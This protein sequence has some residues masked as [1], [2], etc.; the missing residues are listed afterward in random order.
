MKGRDWEVN[1]SFQFELCLTQMSLK[2]QRRLEIILYIFSQEMLKITSF[3]SQ[4]ISDGVPSTNK[5]PRLNLHVCC[6]YKDATDLVITI[7]YI[8]I[9][10]LHPQWVE[11][12]CNCSSCSLFHYMSDPV[13][14]NGLGSTKSNTFFSS[15]CGQPVLV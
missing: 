3:S 12:S 7:S 14:V 1:G 13:L 2:M 4:A 9:S 5:L 15:C 8:N 10:L 11:I 6:G